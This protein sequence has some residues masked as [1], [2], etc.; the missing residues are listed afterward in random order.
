M[1][2][3]TTAT[4]PMKP[5]TR[6]QQ[7]LD[8]AS[9]NIRNDADRVF[10]T[11]RVINA[12]S[13]EEMSANLRQLIDR[14]ES[15]TEVLQ[16]MFNDAQET[17][18][19]MK[20]VSRRYEERLNLGARLFETMCKRADEVEAVM[21]SYADQSVMI[22]K[23]MAKVDEQFSVLS[24][25][26]KTWED[27]A[28]T[29]DGRLNGIAHEIQSSADPIFIRLQDMLDEV[30]KTSKQTKFSKKQAKEICQQCNAVRQLMGEEMMAGADMIDQLSVENEQ[31]QSVLDAGALL[32]EA[33]TKQSNENQATLEENTNA[34]LHKI[35]TEAQRQTGK[36]KSMKSELVGLIIDLDQ[37]TESL[38]TVTQRHEALSTIMQKSTSYLK[39]WE[40]YLPNDPESNEGIPLALREAVERLREIMDEEFYRLRT[41]LNRLIEAVTVPSDEPTQDHH[42]VGDD[43]QPTDQ[44]ITNNT[45]NYKSGLTNPRTTCDPII[46]TN[47]QHTERDSLA[48]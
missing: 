43:H 6:P 9:T 17:A 37:R 7:P 30:D 48:S 44:D 47:T 23:R 15:M 10:L 21:K 28:Q 14:A 29:L 33:I 31:L 24:G 26:V 25:R 11:P 22:E 20:K 18:M 45:T 27:S 38:R 42:T 4:A 40:P 19:R 3:K 41:R 12:N 1:K 5:R 46:I 32:N 13:Y 16:N 8:P 2:E 35:D 34:Q 39:Q 36:I